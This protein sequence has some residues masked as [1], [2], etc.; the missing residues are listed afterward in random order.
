MHG[1][2][3]LLK[4]VRLLM[5]K[6]KRNR[7]TMVSWVR[8]CIKSRRLRQSTCHLF[9]FLSILR[10]NPSRRWRVHDRWV[11]IRWQ[12]WDLHWRHRW[13]RRRRWEGCTGRSHCCRGLL[14][15]CGC[16]V[17]CFISRACG[18]FLFLL[19]RRRCLLVAVGGLLPLLWQWE[20]RW[21]RHHRHSRIPRRWRHRVPR[22]W[23]R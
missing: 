17:F 19:M 8:R 5:N 20:L 13:K 1:I 4:K 11:V 2:D 16:S 23:W 6:M 18:C 9:V 22:W 14:T 7:R 15:A 3:L 10:H 21:R 12:I